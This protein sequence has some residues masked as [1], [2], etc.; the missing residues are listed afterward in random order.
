MTLPEL[1]AFDAPAAWA[2][3]S[4][5]VQAGIG[6]AAIAWM[7]A[8]L[9]AEDGSAGNSFAD[10]RAAEALSNEASD[11]LEE[12]IAQACPTLAWIT[13]EPSLQPEVRPWRPK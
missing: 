4:P 6:A 13:D 8:S 10:R 9:V 11:A 5:D 12:A 3:L 1:K 2:K 7:A